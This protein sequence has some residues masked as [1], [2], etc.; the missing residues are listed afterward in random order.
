MGIIAVGAYSIVNGNLTMGGL[1]ACSII[2]GRALTPLAQMPN[3]I[4][5]WKHAKIALDVLDGI[6]ELPS[7]RGSQRLVVP[8][9]CEGKC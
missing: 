5:Q 4:V 9:S 7:E 1:I 2:S 8:D 6:M 3:M